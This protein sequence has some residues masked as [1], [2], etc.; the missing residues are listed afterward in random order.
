MCVG[1]VINHPHPQ[2]GIPVFNHTAK[3]IV[4]R[5]QLLKIKG[6]LLLRSA[7]LED[8]I[9]TYLY[10]MGMGMRI[11]CVSGAHGGGGDLDR[12]DLD[13]FWALCKGTKCS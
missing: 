1:G 9:G 12:P 8:G 4:K 6:A 10:C 5:A 13:G 7:R 11:T 3:H 2:A